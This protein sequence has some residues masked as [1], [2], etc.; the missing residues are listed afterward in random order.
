MYSA[1]LFSFLY[2]FVCCVGIAFGVFLIVGLFRFLALKKEQNQLF[3]EYILF[4]KE[5]K[6]CGD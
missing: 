4:L 3:K 6:Q 5:K 2:F 1:L